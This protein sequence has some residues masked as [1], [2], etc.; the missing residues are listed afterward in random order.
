MTELKKDIVN[1]TF[2]TSGNLF[3]ES[4]SYKEMFGTKIVEK[5]YASIGEDARALRENGSMYIN[6]DAKVNFEQEGKNVK[7]HKFFGQ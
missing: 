5:A 7:E 2:I 4:K 3:E 1:N 6:K